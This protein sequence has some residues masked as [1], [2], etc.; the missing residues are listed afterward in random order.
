M[1][2]S[3]ASVEGRFSSLEEPK[4]M[5]LPSHLAASTSR[6]AIYIALTQDFKSTNT[7]C[8]HT[9]VLTQNSRQVLKSTKSHVK[10]VYFQLHWR[11]GPSRRV[12]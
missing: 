6:L 11:K 9:L 12:L 2:L 5:W 4:I 10:A 3:L 1:R 8:F 7:S